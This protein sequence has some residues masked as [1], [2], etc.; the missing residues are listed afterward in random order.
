VSDVSYRVG[1][2]E[3]TVTFDPGASLLVTGATA[4]TDERLC[5]AVSPERDEF[6]VVIAANADAS[7]MVDG[8]LDRGADRDQLGVID[9]TSRESDIENVPVRQLSSPGDLTGI[10]LEF[11]KLLD[12]EAESTPVRV[13]FDS[14]STALMY[15]E[16]QTLFRFLH[17]FTAR[18]SS[19]E[20]LGV[21]AM[22]PGMHEEKAYNTIRAVFDAEV[23]IGDAGVET[24]RGTGFTR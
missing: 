13:G 7:R 12:D 10:S 15:T 21:F 19:G 17:V 2:L 16:Q 1:G 22:D 20:M 9:C 23:R 5:D 4:L 11:A 18:I 8:L 3:G 14:V 24:L 6:T